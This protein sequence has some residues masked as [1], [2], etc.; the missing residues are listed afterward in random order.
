[1]SAR[2]WRCLVGV[3]LALA[4]VGPVV[5]TLAASGGIAARASAV[6]GNDFSWPQCAKGVGNG[7]GQPL[8]TGYRQ[9]MIVG[10]TNGTGLH[11]NPCLAG[12]WRYARG[13][14]DHVTGYTV[15]T[16]PTTGERAAARDGHYG[17]CHTLR[18]RLRN[19]G[20][21][22]GA[23]TA[24]SLHSVHA[25]PPMVWVDVETRYRH[26]WTSHPSRNRLVVQAL[27]KSLQHFGYRVG[28]YS[29]NYMWHHLVD[30]ATS[31]PEWV[32]AGSTTRG[33]YLPIS[34]GPVWMSQ[35]SHYYKKRK[36]GYDE[37]G[38][39]GRAPAMHRMF[40]RT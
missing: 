12:Q 36:A 40:E 31:L 34:R 18:C 5:P 17:R 28:I 38:L 9:F 19:H 10:L 29:T 22:Q 26:P 35:Y 27:V 1:M 14:A 3:F 13:H 37:N 4:V 15:P 25:H 11:E 32:P 23:F 16:Y 30:Y 21:A 24:H 8:P 39:C 7:Q 20:W 6:A 2:L 33:C